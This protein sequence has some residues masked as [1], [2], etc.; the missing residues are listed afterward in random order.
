MTIHIV[1]C[2][3]FVYTNV[4]KIAYKNVWAKDCKDYKGLQRMDKIILLFGRFN[5]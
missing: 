4:Y 5:I 2:F 3:S 1:A